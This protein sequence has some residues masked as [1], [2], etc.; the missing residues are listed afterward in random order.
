MSPFWIIV[1]VLSVMFLCIAGGSET[2]L[3]STPTPE[4]QPKPRKPEPKPKPEPEP[5]LEDSAF[6]TFLGWS[7]VA[8]VFGPVV[9]GAA[10]GCL[11][12]LRALVHFLIY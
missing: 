7:A 12:A 3:Y 1:S 10:I 2:R 9:I 11:Y 5:V 4:E 8:V 6:G